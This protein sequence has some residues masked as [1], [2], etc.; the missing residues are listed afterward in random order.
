MQK[1]PTQC[2][3]YL[4]V[5]TEEQAISGLGLEAQLRDCLSYAEAHGLTVSGT[6][7]DEGLSGGLSFEKRPGMMAA[8]SAL[9]KKTIF[10]AAKLDRFSRGDMIETAAIEAAVRRRKSRRVSAAGE[11]TES[12]D[13]SNVL[14]RRMVEA[15]AEYE[16]L[17]IGYRTRKALASKRERGERSGQLPYGMRLGEQITIRTKK[18]EKLTHRLEPDL[19]E[20]K[21]PVR[22][23]ELRAAGM[24]FRKI[25]TC[26][27]E[28]GF[29]TK[30]GRPWRA[31]TIVDLVR[32]H[33]D[34]QE[35]AK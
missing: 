27:D 3:I 21:L 11:G 35:I 12:D 15:F 6:F 31:S 28:E 22:A 24:S 16:L 13:P 25:A 9:D 33:Q 5:S 18:G 30:S 17:I 19:R 8:L 1:Q 4:R 26:F 29:P 2:V 34:S 14:F 10:L 23:A 20:Q 32:R 7:R